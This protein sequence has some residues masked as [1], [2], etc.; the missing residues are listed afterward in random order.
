MSLKLLNVFQYW[1]QGYDMMP[2]FLKVIY[3]HNLNICKKNNINLVLIDDNNVN[4]YIEPHK[5]FN[6]FAYHYKS[7]IIRYYIL[8]KYGGFWFDADVIITKDLNILYESISGYDCMLDIEYDNLIGCCSLFIKKQ[9]SVSKFCVD[10]VN[11]ILDNMKV[12]DWYPAIGPQTAVELYKKHKSLILL[13]DYETVKDGC[14][15]ICWNQEPGINKDKWYL[16]SESLA[17]SKAENLKKNSNCYYLITWQI[18]RNNDMG[19]NLNNMV[20]DDKKSVFS[21]FI[22]YEKEIENEKNTQ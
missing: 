19:D 18:Y 20:F 1:G 5:R 16:E 13:N 9:T 6:E 11:N 4:D 21:Y 7:D 2:S 17:K 3:K 14:N 8:H 10:Y 22:N 15:F 12:L